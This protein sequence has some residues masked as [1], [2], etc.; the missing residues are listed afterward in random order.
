MTQLDPFAQDIRKILLAEWDPIGVRDVPQAQNEYDRYIPQLTR[1]LMAAEPASALAA[2][3]LAVE[4][5]AMGLSGN[6]ERAQKVSEK[7]RGISLPRA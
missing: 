1:M 3:L 2:Y 7:L 4:M 6:R 5:K